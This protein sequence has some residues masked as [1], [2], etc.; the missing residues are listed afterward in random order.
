MGVPGTVPDFVHPLPV[1]EVGP[2]VRAMSTTFLH[3]PH[4]PDVQGWIEQLA[5]RWDEER[6]WGFR[7]RGRWVATSRTE[8]R[9]LTVPGPEGEMA[10][11]EVD[12]LTNV[13]VA[14]THRRQG[15]MSRMLESSLR[16]ASERGDALSVLIA[17]EWPIYGRFGYAPATLTADYVLH[18]NQPGARCSGETGAIRQVELEELAGIAPSLF[19]R[20]RRQWAG[21]M[22][23]DA[24]W[25]QR[26]LGLDGNTPR[27][28]VA[29]HWFLHEGGDGID[30]LLGWSGTGSPNLLAAE[31]RVKVQM[32]FTTSQ[33]AY[34]DL[35][36]YLTSVDLVDQVGL[37]DRPVDEPVRWLLENP[38]ALVQTRR[39][40]F[41]WVRLLD[42]PAALRARSYPV[43]GEL[44]LEVDDPGPYGFAAGR[45]R[46]LA[47]PQGAECTPTTA[48][49]D[50]RIQQRALASAYLGAFRL[51]ELQPA[52]MAEEL[53]P[54]ALARADLMFSWP[55]VP[56]NATWF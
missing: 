33:A 32:L 23:R 35:W 13:T 47:G 19:D 41:L 27:N 36:A 34:R 12:A 49:P 21:Q 30:G 28:P 39:V 38:R 40:D 10:E 26:T 31:Q 24:G 14:A 17:A 22:N 8:P 54:G 16:A 6:A 37:E 42:V 44:V 3:D 11:V 48:D 15:L 18:R 45:Y 51:A 56:W 5:A 53:R 2:W 20:A 7:D 1:E 4:T 52:G 55:R 25:W 9:R 46:L 50:I 43:A 29:P